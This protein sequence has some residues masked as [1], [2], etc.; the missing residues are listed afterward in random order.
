[1]KVHIA[2]CTDQ[3]KALQQTYRNLE[4]NITTLEECV[5]TSK[6][7][8]TRRE[9]KSVQLI[10]PRTARWSMPVLQPMEG[11]TYAN[12][13][14]KSGWLN[15][16]FVLPTAKYIDRKEVADY[17]KGFLPTL[18]SRKRG[19]SI[20]SDDV[21]PCKLPSFSST[22]TTVTTPCS[23]PLPSL[24]PLRAPVKA[25]SRRVVA[26]PPPPSAI[27]RLEFDVEEEDRGTAVL[28]QD[29]N[30]EMMRIGCSCL[31]HEYVQLHLHLHQSLDMMH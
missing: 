29:C 13:Y 30:C 28:R 10:L 18:T 6:E 27:R 12:H 23:A 9:G 22:F 3:C 24:I 17:L 2:N 14:A 8:L 1:M 31:G 19:A 16:L 4:G 15:S 20:F 25:A 7:H 5:R 21:P 26:T 11:R